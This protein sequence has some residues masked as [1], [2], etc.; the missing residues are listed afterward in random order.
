M[1]TLGLLGSKQ[2]LNVLRLLA[3]RD[4]YVSELM[5]RVGM[6]GKT[7]SHH[8]EVLHEEGLVD[9]YTQGRRRYYTLVGEVVVE[10]SPPPNR[11][12]RIQVHETKDV[13]GDGRQMA[14]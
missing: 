11:R 1:D 3:K 10:I 14:E 9:S 13:T 4:M 6:D 2:R 12:V 7:A 5:E 8:L